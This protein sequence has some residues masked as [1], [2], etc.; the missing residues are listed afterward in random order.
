AYALITEARFMKDK[1]IQKPRRHPNEEPQKVMIGNDPRSFIAI[2]DTKQQRI[3]IGEEGYHSISPRTKSFVNR[4]RLISHTPNTSVSGFSYTIFKDEQRNKQSDSLNTYSI[5]FRGTE[6]YKGQI[7]KDLI[8]TDGFIAAGLG[9]PQLISLISFKND[10][11][12]SI[13]QDLSLNGSDPGNFNA[14]DTSALSNLNSDSESSFETVVSGHS[15]GGH[16][17][18]LAC[19]YKDSL[20]IKELYTYNAP[21]FAGVVSS[22]LNIF[23]R[24]VRIIVKLLVRASKIAL[25]KLFDLFGFTRRIINKCIDAVFGTNASSEDIINECKDA[26]SYKDDM[27]EMGSNASKMSKNNLTGI[28]IHH[29]ETVKDAIPVKEFG[30]S[31]SLSQFKEPSISVIS[32]LGYKYGIGLISK[33]DYKNTDKL[34]LLHI[35]ELDGSYYMNS[36]YMSGIIYACYFYNYLLSQEDNKAKQ[37]LSKDIARALDYLNSFSQTLVDIIIKDKFHPRSTINPNSPDQNYI[38]VVLDEGYNILRYKKENEEYEE[39]LKRYDNNINKAELNNIILDLTNNHVYI[40][41]ID[42]NDA[43]CELAKTPAGCRALLKKIPFKFVC[44]DKELLTKR[45]VCK[46]YR[47]NSNFTHSYERLMQEYDKPEDKRMFLNA[48]LSQFKNALFEDNFNTVYISRLKRDKIKQNFGLNEF[49]STIFADTK[50]K[51]IF[52]FAHNKDIVDCKNIYDRLRDELRLN[53]DLSSYEAYAFLDGMALKGGEEREDYPLAFNSLNKEEENSNSDNSNSNLNSSLNSNSDNSNSNNSNSDNLNSSSSLNSNNSSSNLNS[54]S[55]LNSNNSNSN[56]NLDKVSYYYQDSGEE[57]GSLIVFLNNSNV[58]FLKYDINK[59]SLNIR[60]KTIS[61]RA[62]EIRRTKLNLASAKEFDSLLNETNSSYSHPVI[63]DDVISCEHQ[64]RVV[65]R[66]KRGAGFK[67]Q[68][69]G[70]IL[71]SDFINSSIIGCTAKSPCT[72]VALV[73]RSA[74][75]FKMI[76]DEYALMQDKVSLCMSDKG[77]KLICIPKPNKFKLLTPDQ[78]KFNQTS[79]INKQSVSENIPSI[80]LHFK[81]DLSQ[82]DNMFVKIYY[83]NDI[84]FQSEE[85]FKEIALNMKDAREINDKNL[86]KRLSDNYKQGYIFK[87]F[88]LRYGIDNLSL[89]FIMPDH[90]NSKQSQYFLRADEFEQTNK[91]THTYSY[92]FYCGEYKEEIKLD[93]ARGL[94]SSYPLDLNVCKVVIVSGV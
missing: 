20:N 35:G 8:L 19:L 65:L 47:Y 38:S 77:S 5:S 55:S 26:L 13:K 67:S 15:L 59:P 44:A 34:H 62:N 63:E 71:G 51:K 88:D 7:F 78:T 11:L 10:M 87:R 9:V 64:G 76:N 31:R 50:D 49:S 3:F 22:L 1:I 53:E 43:N 2:S 32:D 12:R 33:I 90:H 14:S 58:D 91:D 18:Q 75:S 28:E 16:L 83:L 57:D 66:S 92:V 17:A 30:I 40:R 60:L 21:G 81:S 27:D 94:D 29:I 45:D 61:L 68:G 41:I 70:I 42:I 37:A 74:L 86:L 46:V 73:P 48:N 25:Q 93:I 80:R 72:R 6:A 24:I 4:F 79:F 82:R 23:I 54:S 36:H 56:S 39:F 89:I 84:R 85:G 52:V 69:K